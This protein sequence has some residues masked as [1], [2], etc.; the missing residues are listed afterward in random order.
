MKIV[1]GS[2]EINVPKNSKLHSQIKN[3]LVR[4]AD[5]LP[6][7]H[8]KKSCQDMAVRHTVMGVKHQKIA[9]SFKDEDEGTY[10]FHQNKA[11]EHRAKANA[12]EEK[13][14]TF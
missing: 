4:A 7:S 12:Y 3:L 14:K 10:R 6:L 9:N 2:Q 11:N 8:S 1:L 13:A 5:N